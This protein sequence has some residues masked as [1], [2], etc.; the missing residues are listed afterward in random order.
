M[1]AKS[2]EVNPVMMD[3]CVHLLVDNVAL[4]FL[5]EMNNNELNQFFF[6]VDFDRG[7]GFV[8]NDF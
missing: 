5:Y 3:A 8:V 6:Q 7:I 4:D 2:G 1:S